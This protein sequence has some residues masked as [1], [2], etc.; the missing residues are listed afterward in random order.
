MVQKI[1]SNQTDFTSDDDAILLPKGTSA[2]GATVTAGAL[3]Y[4]TTTGRLEV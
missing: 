1:R 2:Q 3:R 4:N